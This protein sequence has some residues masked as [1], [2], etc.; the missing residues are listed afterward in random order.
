MS[1]QNEAVSLTS[2]GRIV[3]NH[4]S[5]CM[6]ELWRLSANIRFAPANFGFMF[7]VVLAEWTAVEHY[8]TISTWLMFGANWRGRSGR[9]LPRL[10]VYYQLQMSH[11]AL[12]NVLV[13]IHRGK[14][15][16][17]HISIS[18][19]A[20]HAPTCSP[21]LLY[22]P[23]GVFRDTPSVQHLTVPAARPQGRGGANQSLL[24]SFPLPCAHLKSA[25]QQGFVVPKPPP[26]PSYP[27]FTH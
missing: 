23:P 20:A 24:E 1:R 22:L 10:A 6:S 8:L 5:K 16:N 19:L 14:C 11:T 13:D 26:A 27:L 15:D 7:D 17:F 25:S 2:E 12:K 21:S 18:L 4:L 3:R 9:S